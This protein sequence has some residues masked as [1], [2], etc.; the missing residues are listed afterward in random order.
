ME[1]KKNRH[2]CYLLQYHVI[3]IT[4]YRKPVLTGEVKEYIYKLIEKQLNKN[5]IEIIAINGEADH[6]HIMIDTPPQINLANIINVLKT[7]T[8]RLVR[9][10]Y[11]DQVNKYYWKDVFW[12][13]SYFVCTLSE[14]SSSIVK[15]YIDEQ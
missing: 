11:P 3:L 8:S 1:Y 10:D 2:A 7:N 9:R 12:S 13:Q 14:H 5:N 15:K 6:V 4:K